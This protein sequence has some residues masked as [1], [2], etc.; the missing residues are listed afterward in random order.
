MVYYYISKVFLFC[1]W[2]ELINIKLFWFLISGETATSDVCLCETDLTTRGVSN[3]GSHGRESGSDR[4]TNSV[5]SSKIVIV[6]M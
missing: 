1:F 2:K 3:E 5:L 4:C 6:A